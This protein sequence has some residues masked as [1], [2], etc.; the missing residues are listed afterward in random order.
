MYTVYAIKQG[1][2]VLYVGKTINLQRRKC[3]HRYRRRLDKSYSFVQLQTT[4]N[5]EEAKKI[6]EQYIL[7]YDTF[8]NGWNVTAGEGSR[9]VETKNG[10]GR[11]S[12]GNRLSDKRVRKRVK[13]L[14][15]GEIF[16][17][18]KECSLKMG[19]NEGGI[20]KTCDGQQKA[21]KKNHFQY[22]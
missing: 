13:C 14:E 3:E 10:D 21:Y 22:I 19:I 20:Y 17:S 15:T 12:N 6:E 4:L 7:K 8:R 5:K 16:N 11:F 9:L 2:K 18:V 1:E